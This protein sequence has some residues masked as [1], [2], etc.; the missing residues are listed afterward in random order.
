ME[1]I[2]KALIMAGAI[3]IG[4]L[5]LSF[6]VYVFAQYNNFTS[7]QSRKEE[8]RQIAEFNQQFEQYKKDRG[9][10]A[11][12][13]ATVINSARNNN[14]RYDL[15]SADRANRYYVEVKVTAGLNTYGE[16]TDKTIV[17]NN[18][19][20]E[21]SLPYIFFKFKEIRYHDDSGRVCY[22]EFERYIEPH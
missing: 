12:D 6:L 22:I 2:S 21:D 8:N 19:L 16:L 17:Y 15:T 13:M 14:E 4:I 10:R 20:K 11:S 9:W 18:L 7:S 3:L 5:I 1:N